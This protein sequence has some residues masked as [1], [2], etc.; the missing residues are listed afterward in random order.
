[1]KFIERILD[2]IAFEKQSRR[3]RAFVDDKRGRGTF[4]SD[5][6]VVIVVI[7]LADRAASGFFIIVS[8]VH[9]LVGKV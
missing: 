7:A 8:V 1:L 2:R 4:I 3:G 6:A 9:V 5:V